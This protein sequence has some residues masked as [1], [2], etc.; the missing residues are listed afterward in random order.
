MFPRVVRAHRVYEGLAR[1]EPAEPEVQ[2]A[3]P[4]KEEEE[5]PEAEEEEEE[6][7]EDPF[8]ALLQGRCFRHL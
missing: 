2:E 3:D 7:P 6:E 4:V 1:E 5:E 8:P